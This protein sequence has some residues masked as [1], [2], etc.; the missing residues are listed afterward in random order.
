[1]EGQYLNHYHGIKNYST[2]YASTDTDIHAYKNR[3]GDESTI[4][5]LKPK[6]LRNYMVRKKFRKMVGWSVNGSLKK[7]IS[8]L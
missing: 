2:I 5:I 6:T 3:S 1:M 7:Y 4:V 8:A